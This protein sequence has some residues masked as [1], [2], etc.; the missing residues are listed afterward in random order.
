MGKINTV[1][2]PSLKEL[3]Q[4]EHNDFLIADIYRF[5]R[6]HYG[7][8]VIWCDIVSSEL[9][10]RAVGRIDGK[11]FGK[12]TVIDRAQ[13]QSE[14]LDRFNESCFNVLLPNTFYKGEF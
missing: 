14:L 10:V 13:N 3:L 12:P 5:W 6:F 9:V 2:T 7:S 4:I 1:L 8:T 11:W